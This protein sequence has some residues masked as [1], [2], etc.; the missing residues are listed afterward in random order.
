MKCYRQGCEL[1]AEAGFTLATQGTETKEDTKY[2]CQ[3]H[4]D[5]CVGVLMG[6]HLLTGIPEVSGDIPEK[7]SFSVSF[8][9]GETS[10]G[11]EKAKEGE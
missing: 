4:Y 1:P 8:E 9:K 3:R 10:V 11:A 5:E 7:F 6:L 2:F